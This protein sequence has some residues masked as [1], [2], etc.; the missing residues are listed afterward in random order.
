MSGYGIATSSTATA[1]HHHNDDCANAQKL[2]IGSTLGHLLSIFVHPNAV[3]RPLPLHTI[4]GEE[5]TLDQGERHSETTPRNG[6]VL[7]THSSTRTH[8]HAK[9]PGSYP[10]LDQLVSPNYKHSGANQHEQQRALEVGTFSPNQYTSCVHLA[11]HRRLRRAA[12]FTCHRL[13][14]PMF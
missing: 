3:T 13:K 14:T 4:K 6:N 7:S 1:C 10:S 9:R 8:T 5:G 11:H 12:S 2:G